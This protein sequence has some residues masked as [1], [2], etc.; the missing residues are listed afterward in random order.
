MSEK[1]HWMCEYEDCERVKSSLGKYCAT[2][3]HM[4]RKEARE[5][6]KPVR[7]PKPLKRVP[8]KKVSEKRQVENYAY[9]IARNAW[10]EGKR[11]ACCGDPATEVHHQKGRENDLLLEKKY[12]LPV[13]HGCHVEITENPEWAKENGYILPRSTTTPTI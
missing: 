7:V 4:L 5:A 12:W 13:C 9:T 8:V 10:I 1:I 6:S 2:H 11:C 3:D